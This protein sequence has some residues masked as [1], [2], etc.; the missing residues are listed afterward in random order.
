MHKKLTLTVSILT[1]ILGFS[2]TGADDITWDATKQDRKIWSYSA[3]AAPTADEGKKV[4]LGKK[5]YFEKSLSLDNTISCASCHRPEAGFADP[6]QFSKGVGGKLGGRQSPSILNLAAGT[7]YFWDGRAKTLEEQ[8]LGPI[9]N[10]VEMNLP[11]EEALKRLSSNDEYV[12]LFKDAFGEAPSAPKVADAI[13]SYERQVYSHQSPF[14]KW[15][16]GDEKAISPEAKQGFVLFVGK[17]NCVKCHSG[18][19]FTDSKFHNLGVG[20]DKPNPD[21]GRVAISKKPG[22][23]GAFK[24]PGLREIA[25][26]APYFHDGSAK[27]LEE[28]MDVYDKGGTPN[29]WLS[30]LMSELKLSADEKKHLVKFMQALSG[31]IHQP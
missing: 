29:G 28:V 13:A 24:T 10:P 2:S 21:V 20:F 12:K 4:V 18:P 31:Q 16:G 3:P 23:K 22:E 5:L 25:S 6:D 17:A 14:D 19:N 11:I 7:A 15:V 30:P 27:T 9:S 1:T 8:A 26:T